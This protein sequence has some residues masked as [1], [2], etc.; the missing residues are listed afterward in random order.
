TA[1]GSLTATV[2]Y[3][4]GYMLTLVTASGST[5]TGVTTASP[6]ASSEPPLFFYASGTNVTVRATAS[7]GSRVAGVSGPGNCNFA[8]PAT[9]LTTTFTCSFAMTSPRTVTVN[10]MSMG[11]ATI[12]KASPD[13]LTFKQ[14]Q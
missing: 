9:D 5:G 4:A 13:S 11:A 12:E 2:N 7:T 14:S 6:N 3:I 8:P 1:G 10:Y